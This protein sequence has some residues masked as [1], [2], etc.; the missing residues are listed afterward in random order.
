M[1]F[2]SSIFLFVFLPLV[3]FGYYVLFRKSRLLQNMFLLAA[4]LFFYA[5]GEPKFVLVMMLSIAANWAFGLLVHRYKGR[6]IKIRSIL[7]AATV[8]NLG[9]MFV[10]KYLMFTLNNINHVF[11]LGIKVPYIALPIGISFF[12][13]QAF[14]YV[15][16]INRGVGELQKNPLYTGLYISFFPQL[17]A[18]PIVRYETI[19]AEIKNR[20]ETLDDFTSGVTRFIIGFVKKILLANTMAV[21]ADSAF[22]SETPV[23]VALSWLG[24]FAYA[25]QIYF[26][27]SGYSD[28]AIGMGKMFG[29]HFLE[30]FDYPYSS[31]SVTE[32]WRRWHISLGT[33][34]R[35]YVYFPLGGSRVNSKMRLVF[36]LFVV[37]FLTGVWHGANWTFILWGLM[38]FLL[39]TAEK[40]TG[41][42]KKTRRLGVLR[43]IYLLFCV[44]MG[45]VLFRSADLPYA[46]G[47]YRQL[48]GAAGNALTDGPFFALLSQYWVFLACAA[49]FSFPVAKALGKK[50]DTKTKKLPAAVYAVCL[51]AL[52]LIAVSYVVKG[53]YNPFIYFN[54]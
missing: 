10:F 25:F 8:F 30:N 23:S 15:L 32:F 37:W 27:F 35:D 44:L 51:L 24:L 50:V 4:S 18:G 53:S 45:W 11:G 22:D 47:Y 52:M 16:D 42:E 40:L 28:M 9:I 34:F 2:S 54:F 19:A 20:K 46:L 49:L 6:K 13:F 48:F 5:W 36:N 1:L 7:A 38:Y 31:K 3:I 41:F 29:F 12:T 14:S 39:I 17:I 43:N 33:W 21:V 26:D